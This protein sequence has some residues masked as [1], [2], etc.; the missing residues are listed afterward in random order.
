MIHSLEDDAHFDVSSEFITEVLT[1]Y[2]SLFTDE[3]LETLANMLTRPWCERRYNR[4][5]RGDFEFESLRIGHLILAFAEVKIEWL[6][7]SSD[8]LCRGVMQKLCGLLNADGRP[9]VEDAIFVPAVEFWSTFTEEMADAIHSDDPS[10]TPWADSALQYVMA[11]VSSSWRKVSYP[12]T[13][14]LA[15]WD[16]SER[17]GFADARKDVVDMLQST[18]G[19]SGVSLVSTFAE[20]VLVSLDQ[21]QWLELEAAALCL[22]GL[23]DCARDDPLLFQTISPVFNSSLFSEMM[24]TVVPARTRQTCVSLIEKYT[25]YFEGHFSALI[26]ALRLLFNLLGEQYMAA[27]ASKSILRLCSSC[28][29]H[30]QNEATGFLGEYQALARLGK[31]DCASSEKVLGAIACVVQAIPG[32]MQRYD[33]I[34]CLLELVE[35]DVLLAEALIAEP[36]PSRVSCFDRTCYGE[37][38]ETEHPALHVALRAMRCLVSV[39]KG[40]Q[41]PV[42]TSIDL[43][44]D[45]G[46]QFRDAYQLSALQRRTMSIIIGVERLFGS[47]AE[48][49][50]LICATLR[51]GFSEMEP[52]PFVLPPWDVTEYL[53]KHEDKVTRPGMFITTACAFMSSL[54]NQDVPDKSKILE[55][56]LLWVIGLLRRLPGKA[57]TC[58]SN[59]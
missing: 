21:S 2:A 28:R 43:E 26:S 52:G 44:R 12:P 15:Q 3:H 1:T 18:Y 11:A 56:L 7:R 48:V 37:D 55:A 4:L 45:C 35:T 33:A 30:I 32:H 13:E 39:G 19:L 53:T 8:P 24:S 40:L 9:V 42:E 31:L 54:Q 22:G 49:I 57:T 34:S 29:V 47:S 41:A 14:D 36:D 6:M 59:A 10:A 38:S 46:G 20:I 51:C 25:E 17:V 23:S 5:L 50:E 16:S 58:C 27:S